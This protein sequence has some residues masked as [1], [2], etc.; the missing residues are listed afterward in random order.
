MDCVPDTSTSGSTTVTRIRDAFTS[1]ATCD[2]KGRMP[3]DR[4]EPSWGT[5]IFGPP[6]FNGS[7]EDRARLAR[8]PGLLHERLMLPFRVELEPDT[9]RPHNG[10]RTEQTTRYGRRT[11]AESRLVG[12]QNDILQR[13]SDLPLWSRSPYSVS[14]AGDIW[15]GDRA[16]SFSEAAKSTAANAMPAASTKAIR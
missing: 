5:S 3:L 15:A 7:V 2:T 14:P 1:L 6:T 11:A 8:A 13:F 10:S 12:T 9:E 16:R 4:S